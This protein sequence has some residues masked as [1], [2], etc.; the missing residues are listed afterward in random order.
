MLDHDALWHSGG[1]RGVDDIGEMAG[2]QAEGM[3]V[4]IVSGLVGPGKLAVREIDHAQ[5]GE[6]LGA[7]GF[8]AGRIAK[9]EPRGGIVE[10]LP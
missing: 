6:C 5:I 7:E 1:A 3:R 4:G 10:H 2:C 8:A 9:H